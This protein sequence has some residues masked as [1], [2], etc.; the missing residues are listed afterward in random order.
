MINRTWARQFAIVECNAAAQTS[1]NVS[2]PKRHA[3]DSA[4]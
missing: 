1:E 2:Q 3:Q 4:I